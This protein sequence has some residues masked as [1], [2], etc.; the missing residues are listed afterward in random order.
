MPNLLDRENALLMRQSPRWIQAFSIL[1]LLIGGGMLIAAYTVRL[2][3]VVTAKGQLKATGGR[4]D[5]KTP[6]GGQVASVS[7]ANGDYVNSGDQLLRFD[8]TLAKEQRERADQLIKLEQSSLERQ[9]QTLNLQTKTYQQRLN[10]QNLV[11]TEYKQLAESGGIAKIQYLQARD[12]A[13]ALKN[14]LNEIEQRKRTLEIESQK[15]IRDL[16]SQKQA[17]IQQLKY[18]NV[19]ATSSG[20]VFDL[21]ARTSGVIQPGESILSIVPTDGL[22]AEV[23]I[24]NKDI[25]FVKVGQTAKVR[26]DAFPASR[27]GELSGTVELIGA[28]ALPPEPS[29]NYYRF[30]V[31]IQLQQNW[32]E[33]QNLKIPLRSGMAITSNLRIREKRAISLVSDFFSGQLDSIKALRN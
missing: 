26:V 3:E 28:D 14:Q 2:D 25:G 8:T 6:A 23:F 31:N 30:P 10:T 20:I 17:A 16:Q 13:L 29:A 7:V 32:L 11:T 24:P 4:V 12:Q 1:M 9:L 19:I 18:Q 33:T 15:R 21:Q 22:K 27:Y 5:V